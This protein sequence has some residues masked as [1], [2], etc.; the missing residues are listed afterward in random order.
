MDAHEF[1]E[2]FSSASF[3]VL[4]LSRLVVSPGDRLADTTMPYPGF[5]FHLRGEA[6]VT[7]AGTRCLLKG[8]DVL[9]G[10][11]NL[12]FSV[13]IRGEVPWEYLLVIYKASDQGAA[14]PAFDDAPF[15]L[16]V[17]G[18]PLLERTLQSLERSGAEEGGVA[19]L[20]TEALFRL[21]LAEALSCAQQRTAPDA[22]SLFSQA[23]DFIQAHYGE[24]MG[25]SDL[26][27]RMGTTPRRLTYAFQKHAGVAPAAY[28]RRYRLDK[29]RSL[30]ER[31]SA[32]LSAV[33]AATGFT[34]PYQFS[35]A[36]KRRFGMPPGEFRRKTTKTTT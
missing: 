28:L 14:A 10:G 29:A 11:A 24:P 8:S 22:D 3:R 2:R 4:N 20:N 6:E 19:R 16:P 33:A 27:K 35:K 5:I 9:H 1:A 23:T 7:M 12:P 17:D 21:A 15:H 32:P 26:A 18:S 34:D 25:V 30:I 31:S 13:R 36:F